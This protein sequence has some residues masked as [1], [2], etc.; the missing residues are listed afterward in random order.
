MQ[1]RVIAGELGGTAGPAKFAVTA[2]ILDVELPPNGSFTYERPS[3]MDN[4]MFYAFKGSATLNGTTAFK[5]QQA[6][7]FDTRGGASVEL[8]ASADGFRM[9]VFS[10]KQTRES[11]IWHG[12]FVCADKP[13]LMKCFE[14]YQRGKFPPVRVDWDYK[15]ARKIPRSKG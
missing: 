6:C 1:V 2:Q 5:Q 15:D 8:T 9:M 11:I 10:G 13:Q 4:V 12:P 14:N 7:R 3:N